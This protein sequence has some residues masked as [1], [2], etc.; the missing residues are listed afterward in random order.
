MKCKH[1]KFFERCDSDGFGTC[2]EWGYGISSHATSENHLSC[3][4]FVKA[5]VIKI[6]EE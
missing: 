1:C 2:T 3:Q 6:R 4:Y 5:P